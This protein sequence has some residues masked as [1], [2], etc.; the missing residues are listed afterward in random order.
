MRDTSALAL[1]AIL[2]VSSV[3]PVAIAQ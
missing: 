2:L 1:V 3:A